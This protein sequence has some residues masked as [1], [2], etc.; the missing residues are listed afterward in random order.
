MMRALAAAKLNFALDVIGKRADG[1]HEVD[2]ILQS[3]SL[4]DELTAEPSGELALWV[5]GDAPAGADNLVLRAANALREA[6][7]CAKGASLRL[8]KRIPTAAGLGGGSADAAAALQVLNRLWSCGFSEVQL[9]AIGAK[10]GSDIPFC[11]RGGTMRATG[12][13]IALS[14][15]PTPAPMALLVLRPCDGVSTQDVYGAL[16]LHEPRDRADIPAAAAALDAGDLRGLCAAM[17]NSL[18][19]VTLAVRPQVGEA[20]RAMLALG[21]LGAHM[22]GSGPAVFGVFEKEEDAVKARRALGGEV[23]FPVSRGIVIEPVKGGKPC[24]L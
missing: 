1:Y 12:T 20:I 17:R 14:P 11:V 9:A 7:G 3:I 5:Q 24:S 13:G 10:L 2:M 23:C 18:E 19:A 22:S 6:A 16:R 21:A 8:T 15:L 4:Y